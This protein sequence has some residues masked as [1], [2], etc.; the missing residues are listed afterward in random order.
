MR[1]REEEKC[2]QRRPREKGKRESQESAPREHMA[3]MAG[4]NGNEKLG[5]GNPWAG[6]VWGRVW[7]EKSQDTSVDS[8]TGIHNAVG[9]GGHGSLVGYHS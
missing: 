1:A 9:P 8:V 6:E 4:L 7:D 3:K 2:V 5:K